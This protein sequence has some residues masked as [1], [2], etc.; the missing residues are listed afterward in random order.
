MK[1]AIAEILAAPIPQKMARNR[2]RGLLRY[3][4]LNLIRLKRRIKNNSTRPEYYLSVCAIAKNE[5]PYVREWIE[6][7]RS[8]G[9]EKFF[10]YDNESTDDTKTILEPYIKSGVVDYTFF[11][12]IRRQLAAYDDCIEK[13]RFSSRWIAF[14]D[15]DEFIV[16]VRDASIP[17]FLRRCE[18]F[19]AVEINWLI[20]GSGGRREKT[21]G[22]VME[23]FRFHATEDHPLNRMVKSIVDPCRVCSMIGCHEA[24]RISGRVCDSHLLPVRRHFRNRPAQHDVIRINHYAVKSYEEFLGKKARGRARGCIRN[25]TEEY[26]FQYDLNDIEDK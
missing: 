10:I 2:F 15:L 3:G 19:S 6:W 11:P 13:H 18:S 9:V 7:H 14:I 26:F 23:R 16:P 17:A 4:I 24:A 8:H 22:K 1:K 25:R 21:P 5:G 20:Y 12:G